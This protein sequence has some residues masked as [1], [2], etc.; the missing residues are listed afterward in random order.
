VTPFDNEHFK[1]TCSK[2]GFLELKLAKYTYPLRLLHTPYANEQ[3]LKTSLGESKAAQLNALLQAHW[4]ENINTHCQEPGLNV[5]MTHLY[6]NKNGTALLDE[7]EGEKPI[8][9][10]NADLVFSD[11]IPKE[12]H[13]VAL[14]HLHGYKNIG[15]TQ[16]PIVY[17]S[18]P[19]SYSFSEA[20]QQKY[21]PVVT[22]VPD[23]QPM[24][25]AIPIQSGRPLYRKTFQY[26][27]EAVT[28]LR[29]NPN[30]L[31]E[32]TLVVERFLTAAERQLLYQSHDGIIYLIPITKND[33]K[34]GGTPTER[35]D[36]NQDLP[37]LFQAYFKFRNGQRAPNEELMQLFNE[38][39]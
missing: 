12:L 11:A 33:L 8:K 16:Q 35:I 4:Q 23:Q 39:N 32:L 22:L 38:I 18:S 21:L 36:L 17:A 24:I 5:L 13:Y 7:P 20:G 1:I 6:M 31:V 28:W 9:V 26:V 2:P 37:T 3:R 19:L 27:E 34:E 15:S 14:G 25:N 29:A 30:A 10:G